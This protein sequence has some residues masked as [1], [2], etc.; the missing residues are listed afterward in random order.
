MTSCHHLK[1][2]NAYTLNAQDILGVMEETQEY[3]EEGSESSQTPITTMTA[4]QPKQ[5]DWVCLDLKS[6][7]LF[8]TGFEGKPRDWQRR[9]LHQIAKLVKLEQI[10][11]GPLDLNFNF[12]P[13]NGLDLRLEAGLDILGSLVNIE[14]FSF[15][16]IEQ[17]MEEEEVR[18]MIKAWPRLKSV[19]GEFNP[20]NFRARTEA[21]VDM[22]THASPYDVVKNVEMIA[23][24]LFVIP[25]PIPPPYDLHALP[26][27]LRQRRYH[28]FSLERKIVQEY[29]RIMAE[30]AAVM[31]AK[32][33]AYRLY[34]E[35]RQARLKQE[36]INR[37]RKIAPGFLDNEDRRILTPTL[38]TAQVRDLMD[39][40]S[41][42]ILATK[43]ANNFD[44][45]EFELSDSGSGL[46]D[47]SAQESSSAKPT[48]ENEEQTKQ[49]NQGY[50]QETN[51]ADADEEEVIIQAVPL[52]ELTGM[53]RDSCLD[54]EV[55]SPGP[56]PWTE[57]D[58]VS[59][60]S[61]LSSFN[62]TTR[63]DFREF[64]QG[65][66]PPDPW[67]TPVDD[68]TA[69]KDVISQ[70]MGHTSSAQPHDI[71][72]SRSQPQ[73]P[74]LH[75]QQQQQQPSYL[76]Q[77]QKQQQQQQQQQQLSSSSFQPTTDQQT[78]NQ[79]SY[80]TTPNRTGFNSSPLPVAS[81]VPQPKLTGIAQQQEALNNYQQQHRHST[82]SNNNVHGP[83]GMTA[84]QQHAR[85]GGGGA[86]PSPPPLPP[87]PRALTSSPG[88]G[89]GSTT[90]T[91]STNAAGAPNRP[92]LPAR[93][94][95][96]SDR[97]DSPTSDQVI[98]TERSMTPPRPPL[99]PPP[100]SSHPGQGVGGVPLSSP[101]PTSGAIGQSSSLGA[102]GSGR[103]VLKPR[104][105]KEHEILHGIT[106]NKTPATA[107]TR[108]FGGEM[109]GF[110]GSS[111]ASPSAGAAG[112]T[113]GMEDVDQ[114]RAPPNANMLIEQLVNMGFTR[115]Q[116]HSALQKYDYDLEKATN[117]LLDWDN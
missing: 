12:N 9:V 96:Q 26:D 42:A 15:S 55:A 41:K 54:D 66:G 111:S 32:E 93:P 87:P 60:K 59:E 47:V 71:S 74:Q 57:R 88:A 10:D 50:Y 61:N 11:V 67:D 56:R 3:E 35:E 80:N 23:S 84:A 100:P 13:S 2:I 17:E 20:Q 91:A 92:P 38:A 108:G 63:L 116:S 117:H 52:S 14:D 79:Y 53:L 4:L 101:M 64:E 102:G 90:T 97:A 58:P 8:I 95:R 51:A 86:S 49:G 19:R 45:S 29:Q 18:W 30:E 89:N 1:K 27:D 6:L 77:Q 62:T 115:E 34:S 48:K 44:Y 82:G 40:S 110:P 39:N 69:L 94:S 103:P 22:S 68:L 104:P 83:T 81:Y 107:V 109:G 65:L 112:R 31:E 73:Q 5:K 106:N 72:Q 46:E 99:P 7:S 21:I 70:Q 16:N 37:A 98:I 76:Y 113:R 28:D 25:V 78:H 114:Q 33:S 105:P 75:H 36:R 85:F 24:P 43:N